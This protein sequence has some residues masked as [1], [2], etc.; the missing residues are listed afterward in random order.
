MFKPILSA[1]HLE[2]KSVDT[3]NY[4]LQANILQMI[5]VYWFT[6]SFYNYES[7]DFG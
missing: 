6:K 7:I 2:S 3:A 5:A 4:H 1:L